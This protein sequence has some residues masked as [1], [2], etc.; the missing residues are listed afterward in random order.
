MPDWYD[1]YV[2]RREKYYRA[3]EAGAAASI[4]VNH[5][6]GCLPPT[7]S[8][9]TEDAPIGSILA[10]GVSK[11]VGAR[12]ARRFKSDQVA[13]SVDTEIFDTIIS[14]MALLSGTER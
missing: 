5:G 8:V 4:Y 7:G 9:G 12:L 13:L 14:S 10:V 6:E 2:H 11:E 3:V 1:R